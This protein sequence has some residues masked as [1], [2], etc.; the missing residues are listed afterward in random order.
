VDKV[1]IKTS[2]VIAPEACPSIHCTTF[3]WR[4]TRL[5]AMRQGGYVARKR[6]QLEI[7][8]NPLRRIAGTLAV[9]YCP[10]TS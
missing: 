8:T 7:F 9:W 10:D 1:R 3:T 6:N 4:L 2:D 5:L